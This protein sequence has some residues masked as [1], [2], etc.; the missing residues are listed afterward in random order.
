MYLGGCLVFLGSAQLM[1]SHENQ[2]INDI[3]NNRVEETLKQYSGNIVYY[4]VVSALIYAI[5]VLYI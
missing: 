2:K 1:T 5:Q 4:G 3:S